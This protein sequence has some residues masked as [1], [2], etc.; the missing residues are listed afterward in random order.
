MTE[1]DARPPRP[2]LIE[3]AQR[4]RRAMIGEVTDQL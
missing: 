4:R 1:P 2:A 3:G